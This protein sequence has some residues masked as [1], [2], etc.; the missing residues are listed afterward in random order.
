MACNWNFHFFTEGSVHLAQ[1]FLWWANNKGY[2]DHECYPGVEGQG[3]LLKISPTV[4]CLI[5]LT[6]YTPG[7]KYIGGI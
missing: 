2:S 4:L 6:H 3:H 7:T 5:I 1:N